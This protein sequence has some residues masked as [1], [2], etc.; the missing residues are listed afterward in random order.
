[1]ASGF[2]AGLA[3]GLGGLPDAIRYG[4][5]RRRR[6]KYEAAMREGLAAAGP[7]RPDP[8]TVARIA[9]EHGDSRT[10]AVY[11]T[12][13][14]RNEQLALTNKWIEEDR[15]RETERYNLNKGYVAEDRARGDERFGW[16]TEDRGIAAA[17]RERV[18]RFRDE[19]MMASRLQ[20]AIAA[21]DIGMFNRL[22]TQD[23]DEIEKL[24]GL[25]KDRKIVG[26]E[27]I[28][29]PEGEKV[30]SLR[31]ANATTG[32]E[33]PMTEKASDQDDDQVIA[34]T[35]Q[36]LQA[37]ITPWLAK[38]KTDTWASL[39]DGRGIYH[40]GTGE[41]RTLPGSGG[42]PIRMGE[43]QVYD[44]GSGQFIEGAMTS[45]QRWNQTRQIISDLIPI[46]EFGDT[47]VASRQR[48]ASFELAQTFEST[49][50]ISAPAVA[51][52]FAGILQGENEFSEALLGSDLEAQNLARSA[53]IRAMAGKYGITF[54]EAGS[55][56]GT[57]ASAG[58]PVSAGLGAVRVQ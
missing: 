5:E 49:F 57:E 48:S 42:K 1:M 26:A 53:L 20:P 37:A 54:E 15:A 12:M 52:D 30:W 24:L 13:A 44:P 31:I 58:A 10:G 7:G 27:E 6:D 43:N 19:A 35:P 8:G 56:A 29:T 34:F 45:E 39:G 18:G 23:S 16:E 2:A 51:A 14:A 33:G 11:Q 36:Q 55:G 3:Q 41:T 17:E 38:T 9:L 46:P 28:T 50:G 47:E 4:R 40:K 22:V 21:G 32:T 25:T